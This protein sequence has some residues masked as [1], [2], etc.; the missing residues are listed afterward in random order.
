MFR[1]LISTFLQDL[2]APNSLLYGSRIHRV[3]VS[4]FVFLLSGLAH[5]EQPEKI[6]LP[7]TV[8][9]H[10]EPNSSASSLGVFKKGTTLPHL[11]KPVNGF[12]PIPL[13]GS[14]T[15][16][17]DLKDLPI[18]ILKPKAEAKLTS[19]SRK[20]AS[21]SPIRIKLPQGI[22]VDFSTTLGYSGISVTQGSAPTLTQLTL[23][24][25]FGYF[26]SK[27]F[28][29]GLNTDYR[30]TQHQSAVNPVQGNF[31]GTRFN[32]FSPMVGGLVQ[33][34]IYRLDFQFIGDYEL[35]QTTN[36][37]S[38]LSYGAPL[39]VRAVVLRPIY[40]FFSVGAVFE[41]MRFSTQKISDIGEQNLTQ[42][43]TL[44]QAGLLMGVQF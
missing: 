40:Q 3:M 29:L 36:S 13:G 38:K 6:I 27:N 30:M 2:K 44:W 28:F 37:G 19:K 41:Y 18:E 43:L 21:K 4:G 14:K 31:R 15:G 42:P 7:Q 12:Y 8:S 39:G 32:A 5:A 10:S 17:L 20:P 26:V 23:G 33:S 34:W 16:W 11:G 24:A 35:S 1:N 9:I 22:Y 25:S